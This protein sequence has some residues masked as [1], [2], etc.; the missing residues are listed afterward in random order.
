MDGMDVVMF[1]FVRPYCVWV[2]WRSRAR[3]VSVHPFW[4]MGWDRL[5]NFLIC[6]SILTYGWPF[7]VVQECYKFIHFDICGGM[8]VV[9][10]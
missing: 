9:M 3:V 6:P 7:G 1:L 5:I 4:R 10:F 2:A 8:E